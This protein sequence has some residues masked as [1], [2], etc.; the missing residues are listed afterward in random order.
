[1]GPK[2]VRGWE[3]ERDTEN[4]VKPTGRKNPRATRPTRRSSLTAWLTLALLA[5]QLALVALHF[6]ER[7]SAGIH[8][9]GAT[10]LLY[11]L[12]V[13]SHDAVHR[14]AHP[15]RA[16]NE[17]A[18]W[19]GALALGATLPLFRVVHI[20][21][22][23]RLGEPEDPERYVLV[24]LW[25]L[26]L[27]LLTY[28][29]SYYRHWPRLRGGDRALAAV[30]ALSWVALAI[31]L[32]RGFGLGWVVPAQLASAAFAFLNAYLP[33]GPWGSWVRARAP[34]LTGYHDDHH[35]VP[36]RPFHQYRRLHMWLTSEAPPRMGRSEEHT[37]ELQ[38]QSN[39]VCRL[40]LEKKNKTYIT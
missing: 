23:R 32:P 21:H 20:L 31:A 39:L 40:L 27:R 24:P 4:D 34:T 28:N 26:S 35:I 18:G 6:C 16:V 3:P 29:L 5:C 36:G 10:V 11:L 15:S 9:V 22:H 7:I 19:T 30:V 37:S 8:V 1:M 2:H 25:C 14:V 33:H 13:C 12:A 38:S 17:W